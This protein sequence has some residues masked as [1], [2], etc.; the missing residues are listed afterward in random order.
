M[1]TPDAKG[2][3]PESH[4]LSLRNYGMTPC[5][6]PTLYITNTDVA[7]DGLCVIGSQLGELATSI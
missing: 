2:I 5:A 3:F 7:Y 6:W 4:N 1:T